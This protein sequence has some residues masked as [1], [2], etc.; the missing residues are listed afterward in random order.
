MGSN[1]VSQS[2]V[3]RI[4]GYIIAKGNF[5]TATTNLPQSIAILSEGNDANQGTMPTEGTIITTAQQAGQLYGFGSPI[6]SQLRIL[7]PQQGGGLSGIPITVFANPKSGGS[8]NKQIEITPTGTATA[9]GTHTLIIAGREGLD[10]EFYD[11]NINIG[12]STAEIT[13]Y[14]ADAVNNILGCPVIGS[15]TSYEALLTSKWSGKTANEITVTVDTGNNDLGISYSIVSTQSGNGTPD[16]SGA[17]NQFGSTWYTIVLNGYSTD[18]NTMTAL[19]SFNGIPDPTNPTG[20]YTG[21]IMKPFVA[22]TGSTDDN[23]SSFTTGRLANVTIAICPAPQSAGFTFEAAANMCVLCAQQMQ[24][25]PQLDVAGF[26]YPDM[27]AISQQ[28][29]GGAAMSVYNTRDAIV[30]AGC[31]TVDMI[32]GVYVVQDF[33]TTYHPLGENP[34][35]FRYVRNLNIDWNVRFGYYLLE[36]LYVVN[37]VI[38]KNDDTVTAAQVI[39]PKD[40]LGILFTYALNLVRNGLVTDAPFMQKSIQVSLSTTNPDR[41]ETI[42]SYKRSGFARIA[43]TTAT[44]GFNFGTN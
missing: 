37:H 12:D 32:A 40:W 31:S 34:P 5:A 9:N 15:D 18:S 38:A 19:E 28:L 17:L 1:A 35:Q 27:P 3:S 25:S 39:K 33:V 20:R 24:D 42:F 8:T 10:S 21:I 2:A 11:L 16:I 7:L 44:A 30:K 41:L 13:A 23:P 6:Y 22:L 26:A 14:I 43:A 29:W 4:V 36:Q